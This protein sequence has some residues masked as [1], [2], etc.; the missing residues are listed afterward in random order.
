MAGMHGMGDMFIH[1]RTFLEKETLNA[2]RKQKD[3]E[4]LEKRER[5]K[6]MGD[7]SRSL[8]LFWND[9]CIRRLTVWVVGHKFFSK[10]VLIVIMVNCLFLAMD[11]FPP[12]GSPKGNFSTCR[13]S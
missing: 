11:N 4:R 8:Y 10:F 13:L 6:R 1:T 9:G 3:Q 7:P 2:L 5:E 12:T